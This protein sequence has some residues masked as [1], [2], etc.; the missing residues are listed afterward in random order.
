MIKREG[1]EN[2]KKKRT[3]TKKKSRTSN[4]LENK[5]SMT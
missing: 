2:K 5:S 1:K 3:K 4:F